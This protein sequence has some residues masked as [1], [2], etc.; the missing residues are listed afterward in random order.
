MEGS[1]A[2]SLCMDCDSG[3]LF[4]HQAAQGRLGEALNASQLSR[5]RR[6]APNASLP[7][8]RIH[9][10]TG[11]MVT[12][13]NN[14]AW[15]DLETGLPPS[16]QR[17]SG[18]ELKAQH[19]CLQCSSAFIRWP[20]VDP[21]ATPLYSVWNFT[22]GSFPAVA[23]GNSGTAIQAMRG[24][25]GGCYTCPPNT[26]TIDGR[27]RMCESP[28]G[29]GK[30][31]GAPKVVSVVVGGMKG[32]SL[33]VVQLLSYRTPFIRPSSREY[34]LCCGADV[35]RQLFQKKDMDLDQAHFAPNTFY[36]QCISNVTGSKYGG[37]RRLL[38]QEGA[39]EE[40]WS[41]LYNAERGDNTCYS[42]PAGASTGYVMGMTTLSD[43][44]CLAGY[45][46]IRTGTALECK[47]CGLNFH[48]SALMNDSHC[49]PCAAGE[50][51]LVGVWAGL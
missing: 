13:V 23:Q 49:E 24:L 3:L 41:G 16:Q 44:K 14:L 19:A 9:N 5:S 21:S 51:P 28:P 45:Y 7:S 32:G 30:P 36:A 2:D 10:R 42:C 40:C 38:Q 43:C 27:D 31:V 50:A 37:V 20:L 34:F 8:V 1:H 39:V 48:R 35:Q 18:Q 11:C 26:N 25:W 17:R 29:Y 4:N 47:A 22:G 15:I 6:W 46:A 33:P 12:C